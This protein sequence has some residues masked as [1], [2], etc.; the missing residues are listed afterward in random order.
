MKFN[1]KPD[2]VIDHD[3]DSQRG[4]LNNMKSEANLVV[5][6]IAPGAE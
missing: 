2:M 3:D 6:D 1:D 4:T 5:E